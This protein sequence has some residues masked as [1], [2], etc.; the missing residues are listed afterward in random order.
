MAG[1]RGWYR[2]CFE[3]D[4]V[5]LG[6]NAHLSAA[7]ERVYRESGGPPGVALFSAREPDAGY[8]VWYFSP[9]G[10]DAFAPVLER[11][12]F[13]WRCEPCEEPACASVNLRIGA[14]P[15]GGPAAP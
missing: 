2:L 7:L 13:L 12:G 14:A 6:A 8:V 11:D 3:R 4:E 10:Y 9:R 1:E 5:A 15:G